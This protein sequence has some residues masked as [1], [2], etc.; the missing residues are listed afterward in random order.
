M[1]FDKLGI[2]ALFD[3]FQVCLD[4]GFAMVKLK[5]NAA[6]FASFAF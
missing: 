2:A 3:I 5:L 1:R 6:L 4:H